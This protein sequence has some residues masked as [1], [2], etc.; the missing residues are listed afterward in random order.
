MVSQTNSLKST[1]S[2][3]LVK[4]EDK[5]EGATKWSAF[6]FYFKALG[7]QPVVGVLLLLSWCFHLAEI[8]PD[9]WLAAWQEQVFEED[10]TWYLGIWLGITAVMWLSMVVARVSWAMRTT[11]AAGEIHRG[12]LSHILYCSVSFFDRTPSGRVMNR[13]G[14]DQMLVDFTAALQLEVVTLLFWQVLD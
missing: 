8:L 9:S 12:A 14:E 2:G 6:T 7:G 1:R 13:M 10:D 3:T 5:A 4:K 11:V